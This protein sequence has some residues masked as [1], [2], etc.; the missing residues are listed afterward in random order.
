MNVYKDYTIPSTGLYH[1]F[2]DGK[3]TT[4]R[5]LSEPVVY[6][7]TYKNQEGEVTISTKYSWIAW[8]IEEAVTKVLTLPTTAYKQIAALASDEDYGDPLL[9]NI[10]ISRSGTGP[11][12]VYT[13]TPSPRKSP[14]KDLSPQIAKDL[15]NIDL[16]KV[17]A[18]GKSVS[19]VNWLSDVVKNSKAKITHEDTPED[20]VLEDI[21]DEPIDISEIPF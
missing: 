10:K 1:K 7:S 20:V 19:N 9:Y 21:S 17:I 8:S 14:A 11:S 3:V 6:E 12:T 18:S 16:V 5:L 4:F 15:D 13:V 2:E